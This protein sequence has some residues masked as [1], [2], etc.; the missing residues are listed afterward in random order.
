MFSCRRILAKFLVLMMSGAVL[1][2]FPQNCMIM[3]TQDFLIAVNWT[4]FLTCST[5]T[6]FSGANLLIDCGTS[7]TST[8]GTS[9]SSSSSTSALSGLSGLAGLL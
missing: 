7:T 1:F 9:S 5:D 8:T 3:K 2:Q 6:L 4:W